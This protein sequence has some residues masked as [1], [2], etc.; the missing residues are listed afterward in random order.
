MF[1]NVRQH[2]NFEILKRIAEAVL[3]VY[4]T[5][6]INSTLAGDLKDLS[7]S[8]WTNDVGMKH[9]ISQSLIKMLNAN[10]RPNKAREVISL[11]VF[12]T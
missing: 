8:S 2:F 1:F 7:D 12:F 11:N 9:T 6:Q 3:Y 10:V 4:I 5:H